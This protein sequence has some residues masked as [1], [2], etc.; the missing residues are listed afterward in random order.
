MWRERH[1]HKGRKNK[2]VVIN[3]VKWVLLFCFPC[4]SFPPSFFLCLLL[5]LSLPLP[6]SRSSLP[7]LLPFPCPALLLSLPLSSTPSREIRRR[8]WRLHL[9]S[10]KWRIFNWITDSRKKYW[11][12][13]NFSPLL[14]SLPLRTYLFFT[15]LHFRPFFSSSL[16]FSSP[17]LLAIS[18][19]CSFSFF[20][21]IYLLWEPFSST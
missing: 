18:S 15:L 17:V 10:S 14:F 6:I 16:L 11:G 12:S 5:S 19:L 4:S 20:S 21:L 9:M 3:I 8:S 1:E 7:P 2:L 13:V